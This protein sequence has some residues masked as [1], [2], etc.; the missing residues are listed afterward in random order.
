[1][2][3]GENVCGC[4]KTAACVVATGCGAR[5]VCMGADAGVPGSCT[6]P[7]VPP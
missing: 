3:A 4:A 6:P 5:T 2:D 1:V 7:T